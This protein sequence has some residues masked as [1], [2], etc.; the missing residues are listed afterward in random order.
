MFPESETAASTSAATAKQKVKS[1]S[2]VDMG[3][4]TKF[5]EKVK[6]TPNKSKS[7]SKTRSEVQLPQ[8]KRKPS[9]TRGVKHTVVSLEDSKA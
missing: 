7:K 8:P 3:K 5:S 6:K 1:S 9:L 4:V 2:V